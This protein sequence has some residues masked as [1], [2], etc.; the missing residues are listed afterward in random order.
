[1]SVPARSAATTNNS[2]TGAYQPYVMDDV[3]Q[4]SARRRFT[5]VSTFAGGGG[6]CI[7][8]RLAGGQVVLV[9][10]FVREAART[11][12]ANFP[13]TPIDARDIREIIAGSSEIEAFLARVGLR[14]GELDILNGSPP[15]C[16]FSNAGR[17]V[18]DQY[19][20]RKYSDTRQRGMATLIFDF[21]ELARGALPKV[22]IGENVPAL[23]WPKH[24]TLF[25][26][27][28]DTL[29]YSSSSRARLYYVSSAVLSSSDFGVP[30]KRRR[31]FFIGV[32]TDVAEAVGITGDADVLALFPEPTIDL[33][34]S[35]RSALAGLQQGNVEVYPW[36]RMAMTSWI[37]RAISHLP[38]DPPQW[39]TLRQVGLGSETSRFSLV[40]CAWDL[41]APTLT[42]TGQGLNTLGGPIHPQEDRSF[43]IPELKRLFGLPDDFFLTG[44]MGQAAERICRMVPPP[45]MQAIAVRV[46]ERVLRPYAE[47]ITQALT[48][49]PETVS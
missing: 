5:V 17:G 15:C 30:Q 37:G 45:V 14:P 20:L 22:V 24:A 41:P 28:L 7:G 10:E 46:H 38:P 29:R 27:A 21:F 47:S 6:S 16:E 39:L 34:V 12:A 35:I 42:V 8:Y 33:P 3:R 32:R 13:G 26:G 40:R 2:G 44:T 49:T 1:M 25:E 9:N 11:Y 48:W 18:S 31:L 23:A 36:R 19:Q 4:A 43:T